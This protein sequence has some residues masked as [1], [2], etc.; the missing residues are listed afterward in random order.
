MSRFLYAEETTIRYFNWL[1]YDEVCITTA[2]VFYTAAIYVTLSKIVVFLGAEHSRFSPALYYW[3]FI[4]CD[5][6]SLA[7]QATGGAMSANSSG[8]DKVGVD[9][10]L[11]GLSFQV[12]SLVV[13]ILLVVDFA[14]RY[15]RSKHREILPTTFKCFVFVLSLAITLILVRCVYRIDELS[16]GYKG[17]LIHNEGLFIGL[18]GV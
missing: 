4:P 17:P 1:T 5:L 15:R 16:D 2:P 18:E 11:A 13:F 6:V 9:I 14:F 7:L 8:S 10:S 3:I 12:C